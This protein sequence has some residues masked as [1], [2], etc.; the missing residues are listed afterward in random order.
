MSERFDIE[1]FKRFPVV[2]ILRGFDTEAVLRLAEAAAGAG[3]LAL[4][5][6][7][8]RPDA[9]EQVARVVDQLGDRL[10]VGAGT[11][12]TV[13]QVGAVH[14]AGGRFIVSPVVDDEVI[15]ATCELGLGS[16]PGALSPSEVARAHALGATMVKV[17]P[18]GVMGP[19]Y[20]K[21]L[22]GPMPGVKLLPTG[23][24]GLDDI[25]HYLAAGADG[26]GLGSPLFGRGTDPASP[27][28]V[29]GRVRQIR[30]LMQPG[31]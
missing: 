7:L 26:F 17:F 10:T 24:V 2:G 25:P 22:K 6:T 31:G 16:F 23:S 11:V 20:V 14:R 30:D 12:M 1:R 13:E 29:A 4:E 3:L 8:S 28:E 27:G 21:A 5:V 9:I 19:K 15:R 18:G